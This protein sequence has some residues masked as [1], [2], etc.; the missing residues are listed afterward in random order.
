MLLPCCSMPEDPF[1]T[2]S[3]G[4]CTDPN[5]RLSTPIPDG[6]KRRRLRIQ[7]AARLYI[8]E[9]VDSI[10]E[11][12]K[13]SG[14]HPKYLRKVKGEDDWDGYA[15]RVWSERTASTLTIRTVE[16]Q[17]LID[18]EKE[19]QHR[20]VP[21][22][23]QEAE[24]LIEAMAAASPGS[25]LHAAILT[26]MKTVRALLEGSTHYDLAKAEAAARMKLALTSPPSTPRAHRGELPEPEPEPGSALDLNDW[27][28]PDDRLQEPAVN[29]AGEPG[30]NHQ[31]TLNDKGGENPTGSEQRAPQQGQPAPPM[32]PAA[33]GGETTA[34]AAV[35]TADRGEGEHESPDMP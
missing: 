34:A 21:K 25:K 4:A 15:E 13:K 33:G 11:L 2:T 19:R 18:G 20:E 26:A 9:G 10:A 24:R 12:S 30:P 1:P 7:H 8:Y 27:E 28:G 6:T 22:L 35:R 3:A 31:T 29:G 32:Q 17:S 14:V 5:S 23:Q 16:E